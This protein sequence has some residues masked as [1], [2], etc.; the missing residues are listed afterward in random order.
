MREALRLYYGE[1]FPVLWRR[2][3]WLPLVVFWFIFHFGP[4]VARAKSQPWEQPLIYAN[5]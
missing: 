1:L 4:L 3:R 2:R 5:F